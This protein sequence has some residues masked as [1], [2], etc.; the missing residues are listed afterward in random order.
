M[1]QLPG[2]EP[3]PPEPVETAPAPAPSGIESISVTAERV[4]ATDV[5][6]E[7]QAITAFGMDELDKLSIY[8]IDGLAYNVPSLHIGQQGQSAI[9]TLRGVGTENAT[10]TGEAGVAFLVDGVYFGRPAAAR[11]AFFDL[12]AIEVLR[13]PQGL[14][15][16]KNS[17]SGWIH[18]RTHDPTDELELQGDALLGNYDR[19]R[20]RGMLNVP[21]DEYVQARLALFSESRDGF[22]DNAFLSD[23][24]DPFDVDQFGLRGKLKFTPGDSASFVLGYNYFAE[25]GTGPQG[26]LVPN[27]LASPCSRRLAGTPTFTLMPRNLACNVLGGHQDLTRPFQPGV[28]PTPL[29]PDPAIEDADP[30]V[31]YT[32]GPTGQEN[33]YWGFTGD[34][35]W[36]L[37]EVM[38]PLQLKLIG[39]YQRSETAFDWDFDG[40][41][42]NRVNLELAEGVDEHTAELQLLGNPVEE[43][44]WQAS[45]SFARHA[46]EASTLVPF[47]DPNPNPFRPIQAVPPTDSLQAIENKSYG[48]SLYLEYL[49]SDRITLGLGGR[50]IKDRK[51]THLFR[52][53][54]GAYEACVGGRF[55]PPGPGLAPVLPGC[56]L[57]DRGTAWGS[58]LEFRPIDDHLLYAGIDRG[59]KSGGFAASGVGEYD[60]ETIWAYTLGAKS[61]FFGGGLQLNLEGF[62]YAYDSMQIALVDGTRVRTENTD[63]RMY[64]WEL[65]SRTADLFVPGLRLMGLVSFLDTEALDYFTLDPAANQDPVQEKRLAVRQSA[66]LSGAPFPNPA[67][68]N[69]C[70]DPANPANGQYDCFLLGDQGGLDDFSGNDLSRSP[71]WKFSFSAE[72]DIELGRFGRLTP[73][74]Q[75][76]WQDDTYYRV[77]NRTFDEQEAFH[78]TDLRLSWNSPESAWTAEVFVDNVEDE[79]VK[80]NILVGPQ[81]L[82]SPP[83][84]WYG[85]PRFY[86]FRLGFKY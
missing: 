2:D 67:S 65:E 84:A 47:S 55:T 63:A 26:D 39:A 23:S 61:L 34:L 51:R 30:R 70:A 53:N 42:I 17:T 49:A 59:Y 72:Y 64:G 44:S 28:N 50:W 14:K 41:D 76:T 12:A 80:Q 27:P 31:V 16:G 32:D 10:L 11:V 24:D 40:S 37:P 45:L 43:L 20:Y 82:G 13:G 6:D 60:P 69:Q 18:A 36:D 38:G 79:A 35:D 78:K 73:R 29:V 85:E 4:D 86:G 8:N 9:V 21:L 75:Y 46:G 54:S 3:V 48:A 7:A 1:A 57:T 68:P 71:R 22:L 33:R 19:Q 66:D 77:F 56:D 74:A 83:L 62:F 52:A 58:R 25:N 81:T 5:Q 15:G